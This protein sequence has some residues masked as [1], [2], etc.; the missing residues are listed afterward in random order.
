MLKHLSVKNFTIIR[1]LE[2]DFQS[3]LLTIT[4]ETGAGKSII[5]GALSLILGDRADTSVLQG[6]TEKC[7]VEGVF[8]TQNELVN[9]FFIDQDL[10]AEAHCTLRREINLQGKSRAFINDTPVTLNQLKE[11]GEMLVDIHSQHETLSLK[12]KNYQVAILDAF[13]NAFQ[14][15]DNYKRAF[16]AYKSKLAEWTKLESQDGSLKNEL[17]FYR[18]QLNELND[19]ALQKGEQETL[20]A[21]QTTLENASEIA[22]IS[23]DGSALLKSGENSISDQLNELLGALKPFAKLDKRFYDLYERL[24]SAEIEL[25]D[26]SSEL[27][28]I[29]EQTVADDA[30]LNLVIERLNTIQALQKKHRVNSLEELQEKLFWLEDE[31]HRIENLDASLE[32]TRIQVDKLKNEAEERAGLLRK[33]RSEHAQGLQDR[34][35]S[36]LH[37]VGMPNAR[38]E[39]RIESLDKLGDNGMDE[40]S[41]LFSSNPGMPVQQ[42]HKAASGG[43]LSRL[44]LCLK[45]ILADNKALPTLIFD[46]IDTGISG[47]VAAKVAKLMRYLSK[48]HQV[49]S[50]THLPQIAGAGD[51][52]YYVHKEVR[53]NKTYTGMKLLSEE[54]R[55]NELARMLSGE[56]ATASAIANAKE[57]IQRA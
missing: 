40:V 37:E 46:E 22:K 33:K 48:G 4:G 7:V 42:I 6:N 43:E 17:D 21:E 39:V 16:K 49:F 15:L 50:I 32:E 45:S 26:I 29:A 54:E 3:G 14:E 55:L 1:E 10:D 20:E 23:F 27:E 57:L 36:L 30:R 56:H 18:F 8:E 28:T 52:H 19:A 5:L 38:I 53:D 51:A 11:L 47:E 24:S 31:V 44:M 2:I 35:I 13:A 9:Q 25:S 34:L 41:I 12:D